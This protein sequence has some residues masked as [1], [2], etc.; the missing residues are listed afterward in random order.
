M[1]ARRRSRER[2]RRRAALEVLVE[3]CPVDFPFSWPPGSGRSWRI[4][5]HARRRTADRG[6]ALLTVLDVAADPEICYSSHGL[7][8]MCRGP[9]G[10]VVD[11]AK[12]SVVTVLL[13]GSVGRWTDEDARRVF[14]A[15]PPAEVELREDLCR[16]GVLKRVV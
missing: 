10:V 8:V 12:H 15:L 1:P 5:A 11:E 16:R 6:L 2:E 13:R 14:S 9:V 4:T 7:T 3:A